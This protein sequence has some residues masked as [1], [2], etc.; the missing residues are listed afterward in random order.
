MNMMKAL[1][2][3]LVAV[4]ASMALPAMADPDIEGAIQDG[5]CPV[6]PNP[7][8]VQVLGRTVEVP[9]GTAITMGKDPVDCSRIAEGDRIK[10][11]CGDAACSWAA[12]IKWEPNS[13]ES[14][15]GASVD[16]TNYA[17]FRLRNMGCVVDANTEVKQN[18]KKNYLGA[19][20]PA[21]PTLA[22]FFAFMCAVPP[23]DRGIT[24]GTI[25]VKCVGYNDG[26]GRI[27]AIKVEVKK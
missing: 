18:A 21:N 16:C 11:A 27:G 24:P 5:F 4:G 7:G 6:D 26:P 14:E 12:G 25:E 19:L 10:I 3:A 1:G 8:F 9:F 20:D 23:A 22:E 15:V 13:A 2:V 17:G